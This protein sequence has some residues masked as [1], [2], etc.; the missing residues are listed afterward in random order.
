MAKIHEEIAIIKLS[1]LVKDGT[2]P[3][4]LITDS[5]LDTIS[6]V[7]EELVGKGVVVELESADADRL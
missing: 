4:P 1:T 6:S 7:V 5:I 3:D 2:K